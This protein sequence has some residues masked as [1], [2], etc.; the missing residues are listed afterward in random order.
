MLRTRPRHYVWLSVFWALISSGAAGQ[1][2]EISF[3]IPAK[4]ISDALVDFAVQG[5]LSI[6]YAG[7]DFQ[8][9]TSNPVEGRFQPEEALRLLLAGTG[10]E[11]IRIDADTIRIR[12]IA[13]ASETPSAPLGI[14]EIVITA[15][16]RS[17]IA[18]SLPYSVVVVSGTEL[19]DFG[20]RS[21]TDLTSRVAALSATNFGAGQDKLSIRGLSDSAISGRSQSM[22]G[23]YLDESH[24]TDNA[25]DP[26]LRLVDINRVEIMRGPQGTLYGAGVLG[27]L[28]RIIPNK[29][30]LDREQ[31]MVSLSTA[32]TQG[33]APSGGVDAMLNVPLVQNIL[34][35]RGAGYF[36][37]DGGFI[38]DI[39][40]KRRNVNE[41]DTTGAR[42]SLLW[43]PADAW[44]V[45]A[46]LT[47]QTI[48]AADSQYFQQ[49]LGPLRRANS[50]PEPHR[51]QFLQGSLTITGALDWANLTSNSAI[52]TRRIAIQYDASRAWRRLTGFPTGPSTFNS[53]RDIRWITHE[54]RLTSVGNTDW[55]WIVG[56]FLSHRDE[57]YRSLLVGPDATRAPF[58]ARAEVRH[59]IANEAALFGEAT[60]R[61]VDWLSLT[62]GGRW[63][64]SA[65]DAVAEVGDPT[66][67]DIE[68]VDG[69]NDTTGFIRKLVLSFQPENN[70]ITYVS[71]SE[72]FRLGGININ[73]PIGAINVNK[74]KGKVNPNAGKF[75]SDHLWTYEVGSKTSFFGGRLVANAAAYFTIWDNIQSDQILHD[76]SLFTTNAGNAHV[77]GFEFDLS[78]QATKHLRLQGNAFWSDPE[79]R[80]VN[81]LLI[82]SVGRLPVV[83][84]SSFG[85]SGHYEISPW[86]GWDA[87]ATVTYA[88]V[89]DTTFGFDARKSAV[90]G[91][92]SNINLRVGLFHEGWQGVLYVNNLADWRSNTFAFANPFSL[93]RMTPVTPLRPR[94]IGLDVTW[95]F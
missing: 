71:A 29:P 3:H 26:G 13:A 17:E 36:R 5:K 90:M 44:S 40:L 82:K 23:L 35:L 87:F 67:D 38:D 65:L 52:T 19:N 68:G 27:G 86:D 89:G 78:L 20:L 50:E 51:D 62:A 16:K 91:E 81:P 58:L 43:Q 4:P 41:T 39:Q 22:V 83:P 24:L 45:M 31:G 95:S 28:V 34:A 21:V 49:R 48:E 46:S 63:F 42:L 53:L 75:D 14:E 85:V 56:A 11:P 84:R 79:I 66:S 94:T 8:A 7:L 15:T 88:Y 57:D 77:P 60:Y 32:A 69:K 25:P 6:G 10:Y 73:S 70:L 2:D 9:G 74:R 59:D 92:Y 54:T 55:K 47:D 61:F 37:R 33:G 12:Q 30:M 72:G 64:Y 1:S 80:H 76:G 18:Q 93:G